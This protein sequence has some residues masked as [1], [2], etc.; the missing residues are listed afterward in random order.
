MSVVQLPIYRLY[1]ILNVVVKEWA[2]FCYALI[3]FLF[4]LF[5]FTILWQETTHFLPLYVRLQVQILR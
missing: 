2:N 3:V 1:V 4:F 5:Y